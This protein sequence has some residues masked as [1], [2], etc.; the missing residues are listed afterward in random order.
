MFKNKK[1]FIVLTLIFILRFSS[2]IYAE[3]IQAR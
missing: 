1:I 2:M 3:E